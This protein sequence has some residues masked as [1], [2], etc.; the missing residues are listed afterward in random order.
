MPRPR[1]EKAHHKVL[2]AAVTL[3]AKQGIDGTSMDAIA[4]SSG[5]SKATIYKHW[6]DKDALAL[7]VLAWLYRLDE[8]LPILGHGSLR[9]D[10]A[11]ALNYRPVEHHTK[12]RESIMPHL[13]AYS[14]RNPVFGKAWRSRVV[15][16][17]TEFLERVIESGIERG[18]LASGL[19]IERA[20]AQLFGPLM[21]RQIFVANSRTEPAPPEF[22]E[23]VV[24]AFLLAF[25]KSPRA[26]KPALA[27]M[28]SAR[29]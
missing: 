19:T 8:Q 5:V 27:V 29:R 26:R 7:E 10:L 3:F 11:T 18:E 1:S 16:R 22:V 24:E 15:K 17:H 4:A 2:E 14:A 13:M 9:E 23:K 20:L 21:Y 6:P 12:E 25:A 28:P